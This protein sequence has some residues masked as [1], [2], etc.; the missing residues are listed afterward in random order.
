MGPGGEQP[1]PAPAIAHKHRQGDRQQS[2]LGGRGLPR[3]EKP[4]KVDLGEEPERRGSDSARDLERVQARA[5]ELEGQIVD[6]Q[7]GQA[8][9]GADGQPNAQDQREQAHRRQPGGAQPQAQGQVARS[10]RGGET[11]IQEHR[12]RSLPEDGQKGDQRQGEE[13]VARQGQ[14]RL[15]VEISLPGAQ[16]GFGVQPVAD[17]DQQGGR[18]EAG[19]PLEPLGV[20]AGHLGD[21]RVEGQGHREAGDNAGAAAGPHP[22]ALVGVV[23]PGQEGEQCPHHQ[24]GLESLAQEKKGR[25]EDPIPGCAVNE[26]DEIGA[27]LPQGSAGAG[28]VRGT[29]RQLRRHRGHMGLGGGV[30]RSRARLDQSLDLRPVPPEGGDRRQRPVGI[31]GVEAGQGLIEVGDRSGQ[32]GRLGDCRRSGDGRA[33]EESVTGG[34]KA[35][36]RR[37]SAG[38]VEGLSPKGGR[39]RLHGLLD[40]LVERRRLGPHV[41][42]DRGPPVVKG[43][44]RGPRAGRVAGRKARQGGVEVRDERGQVLSRTRGGLAQPEPAQQEKTAEDA[45]EYMTERTAHRG[46]PVSGKYGWPAKGVQSPRINYSGWL[47]GPH[48]TTVFALRQGFAL[49]GEGG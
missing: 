23:R 44:V 5:G 19:Q 16:T 26:G 3:R 30:H 29:L 48:F 45:G 40:L 11:D 39:S 47:T 38:D 46:L 21:E 37:L 35:A 7:T 28:E 15:G 8:E 41:V 18:A 43:L 1:G 24:Q 27:Q 14:A 25:V 4:E 33:R 17:V 12:F 2:H 22:A 10:D 42:F 6:Q 34:P 13:A 20:R 9:E 49:T 32:G 31:G 36:Q